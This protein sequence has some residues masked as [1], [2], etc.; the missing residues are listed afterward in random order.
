MTE[1]RKKVLKEYF[2][3]ILSGKKNFE[4]RIADFECKEGDVLILE[5]IDD[6]R[7]YTGRKIE[8]KVKYIAKTKNFNF[9]KQEDVDKYGFQVIGFD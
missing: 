8:K 7:N 1:I 9:F 6:K 4:V 2:E 5:E 3:K